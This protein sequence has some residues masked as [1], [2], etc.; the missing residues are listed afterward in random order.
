MTVD[1]RTRYLGL[2]LRSPIVASASPH[3]GRARDGPPAR[4]GRRRRRSCC[5]RCSR[6]RSS[7]E[8]LELDARRS[9][10]AP[11]SSPRRSTTSRPSTDLVGAAT[12][13]CARLERVKA[14]RRR[15]GHRAASTRAPPG[16][17]V[18][19]ARADRR[20]PAPTPSSSTCTTSPPTRRLTAPTCEATD[21]DL[22]ARRARR[23]STIPL[24]VKLSPFYSALAEL[25]DAAPCRTGADG[26][27]LFNRFYQPDLDLETLDVVPR[28]E[29]QPPVGAAPARCAGSRSC[30]RSSAPGVSLGGDLGRRTRAP[31]SV[32]ALL[33]GADVAMMTSALLRARAGAR[34]RRS[35]A[36]SCD[37]MDDARVRVGRASCAAARAQATVGDPTAF[38]RA[39]YMATLHS[40]SSPPEL[41]TA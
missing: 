30:A 9:S 5:R 16:G 41:A 14:S 34:R 32:K 11:S 28:L 6:R 21:L 26:L 25:R 4:A 38:E 2:D 10:R 33:V 37:W 27:V 19:Y 31:T 8:E 7:H 24:A 18:R 13:T 39:N 35:S 20:R 23:R 1:L 36:S 15:P 17:W 29:L 40:W 3:N 22:I 12:A